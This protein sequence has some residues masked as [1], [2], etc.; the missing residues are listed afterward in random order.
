MKR[1]FCL[2]IGLVFVMMVNAITEQEAKQIVIKYYQLLTT[3]SKTS[4]TNV[5]GRKNIGDMFIHEEGW[6][7]NDI[8][9]KIN[10]LSQERDRDRIDTYIISMGGN[11]LFGAE[12]T[13]SNI[14]PTR[15]GNE[16][17]VK[18][19]MRVYKQ[20][21]TIYTI[22]LSMQ[23][24]PTGKIRYIEK[25]KK[26][27]PISPKIFK[28]KQNPYECPLWVSDTIIE[29]DWNYHVFEI[30]VKS[31]LEWDVVLYKRS[32]WRK[33]DR[34]YSHKCTSWSA[35]PRW[36]T[37]WEMGKCTY[38]DS[39]LS[40]YMDLNLRTSKYSDSVIIKSGEYQ[41]KIKITQYGYNLHK[42]T[43]NH[44]YIE[45]KGGYL[46]AH[47]DF[48]AYNNSTK[49]DTKFYLKVGVGDGSD[50][51]IFSWENKVEYRMA[52]G[53]HLHKKDVKMKIPSYYRGEDLVIIIGDSYGNVLAKKVISIK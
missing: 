42:A 2:L 47:V 28:E 7:F 31:D 13:P 40:V 4:D 33:D 30:V 52:S 8:E 11:D 15:D 6:I 16:W 43:I 36:F 26:G 39:I 24:D 21:K 44:Y 50:S 45:N 23:I 48:D 20:N 1:Y 35:V 53:K 51:N 41:K 29:A 17:I 9:Y 22:P 14:T 12:F 3:V 46:I 19:D 32:S 5:G 34:S 38:N 25:F 37:S 27:E 49:G 18:Y 10:K